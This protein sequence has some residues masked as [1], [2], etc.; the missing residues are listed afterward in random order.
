MTDVNPNNYNL[1]SSGNEISFFNDPGR[2][3]SM[4]LY[5]WVLI[6]ELSSLDKTWNN[7][8][9]NLAKIKTFYNRFLNDTQL[10]VLFLKVVWSLNNLN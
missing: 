2:M 9:E 10:L 1:A 4:V 6:T 3:K 8:E 7:H 5:P